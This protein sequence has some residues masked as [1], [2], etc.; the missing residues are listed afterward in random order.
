MGRRA[1]EGAGSPTRQGRLPLGAGREP[2]RYPA[3]WGRYRHG[4]LIMSADGD[5][6]PAGGR[7][8]VGDGE[9]VAGFP[10]DDGVPVLAEIVGRLDVG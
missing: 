8:R 10:P 7:R 9:S 1:I 5:E 4:R 6:G 2:A 3:R